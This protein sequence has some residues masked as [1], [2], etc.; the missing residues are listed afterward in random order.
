MAGGLTPI[1][2][3]R[4]ADL[5][6]STH[7]GHNYPEAAPETPGR[8][9]PDVAFVRKVFN[10]K[11][12]FSDGEDVEYWS[13]KDPDDDKPFPAT[14]IRVR[15]G[16]VVH[17]TVE[18][19]INVHTIHHHGIEPSTYNDG[20]PDTSFNVGSRYTYQW[21]ASRAGTFFYHCHRNAPLH[22][23]MGMFGYL[24]ID[25]PSGP[26]RLY[27]GGP[28]YDVEALWATYDIDP[29]WRNYNHASGEKNAIADRTRLNR[30]RPRY[31]TVNGVEAARS[32][33]HPQT[34]VRARVGQRILLRHLTGAYF[35][36]TVLFPGALRATVHMSDGEL[37][38]APMRLPQNRFITTTAERYDLILWPNAAG[39]HTVTYQFRH[40]L[41]GALAGTATAHVIVT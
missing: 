3:N 5:T 39:T 23:Q 20:V 13:F 24:I 28:Q 34:T 30:F 2:Q 1:D 31:F 22:V 12:E 35:V 10:D 4:P 25:P 33:N 37:L 29:A 36:N 27:V 6:Q 15:Q 17:T 8:V 11:L 40:W 16:Q 7:F 21:R 32:R 41:T 19:S 38:P 18:P 14:T 9:R 26:G